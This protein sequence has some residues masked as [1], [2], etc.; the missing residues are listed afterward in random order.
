MF[1][2]YVHNIF[3]RLSYLSLIS[4]K[5]FQKFPPLLDLCRGTSYILGEY[6]QWIVTINMYIN[7][8]LWLFNI[9]IVAIHM[10]IYLLKMQMFQ[11]F[12][13][14]Y[15]RVNRNFMGFRGLNMDQGT[16]STITRKVNGGRRC[17]WC[18]IWRRLFWVSLEEWRFPKMGDPQAPSHPKPLYGCFNTNIKWPIDLD[19]LGGSFI[20]ENPHVKSGF[21]ELFF[22][23]EMMR[24]NDLNHS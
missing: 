12:S 4:F 18:N 1:L 9:T 10:M 24:N 14:V 20:L 2:G 3:Y 7:Y 13:Y 22:G 16:K 17:T 6:W 21:K 23:W 11:I 19:N 8:T 15:P 5:R